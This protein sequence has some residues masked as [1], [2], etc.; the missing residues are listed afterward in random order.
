MFPLDASFYPLSHPVA[1][2]PPLP[3]ADRSRRPAAAEPSSRLRSAAEPFSIK[4]LI[5][6][7]IYF[8][9]LVSVI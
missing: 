5:F 3:S 1:P 7:V 8:I 9:F 4:K 6:C 2:T